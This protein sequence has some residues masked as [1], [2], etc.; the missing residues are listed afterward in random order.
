MIGLLAGVAVLVAALGPWTDDAA[1]RTL[2][3]HMGQHMAL[4][5]A[6]A[7]LLVL[8][9]SSLRPL[10]RL[11]TRYGRLLVRLANPAAAWLAFVAAQWLAH[12]TGFYESA[13]E[14]GGVHL[15]EHE[16]FLATAI[17]FWWPVLGSPSRLHGFRRIAYVGSAMQATL[18]IGIVLLTSDRVFYPHYPSLSDQHSA[19]A[20]MW[21]VGSLLMVGFLLLV[22]WEWL[23]N[24]ERR[25]VA[26][27]AYGR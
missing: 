21:V 11:P 12:F 24:E 5:M 20:L 3:A 14:N 13:A 26:R 15:L 17:L 16:L 25:A 2:V 7:P 8:G 19:G 1:D 9:L 18:G 10:R 4:T 23:Q 6:A 22:A 27:E